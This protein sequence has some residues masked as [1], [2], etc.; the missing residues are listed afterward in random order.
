MFTTGIKS[1]DLY[2]SG[3]GF[4]NEGRRAPPSG[5]LGGQPTI[6]RSSTT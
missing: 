1:L 2:F 5:T 4:S 3:A 6:W